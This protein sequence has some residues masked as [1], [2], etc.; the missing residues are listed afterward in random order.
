[1]Y[2]ERLN[3]LNCGA[4]EAMDFGRSLAPTFFNA[5]IFL[6]LGGLTALAPSASKELPTAGF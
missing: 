5:F 4:C 1:M 2:S 3:V 6:F